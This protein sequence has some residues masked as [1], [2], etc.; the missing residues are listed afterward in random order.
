VRWFRFFSRKNLKRVIALQLDFP[1]TKHLL[2]GGMISDLCVGFDPLARKADSDQTLS[3]ANFLDQGFAVFQG[4]GA[5][6]IGLLQG[7][8]F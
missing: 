4:L 3:F 8:G 1:D 5:S 2:E 7:N 6:G